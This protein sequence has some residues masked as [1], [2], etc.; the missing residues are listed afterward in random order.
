M[1]VYILSCTGMSPA[2]R[3]TRE[4]LRRIFKENKSSDLRLVPMTPV[5]A[6][7]P[8]FVEDVKKLNMDEMLVI[9]GCDS[10]CAILTLQR[11]E[12]N[13]K[14]SIILPR[15]ASVT[16]YDIQNAIEQIKAAMEEMEGSV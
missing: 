11:I 12:V 1:T 9:D 3:V 16:E 8:K 10:N 15:I 4:A 6:E 2:G 14:K 7:I 13:P 5:A